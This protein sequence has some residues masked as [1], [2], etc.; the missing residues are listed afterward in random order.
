MCRVRQ[1]LFGDS[2]QHVI[3]YAVLI[4]V[5]VGA[6]I[7]M[8]SYFTGAGQGRLKQA[9]DVIGDEGQYEPGATVV[10]YTIR[11]RRT[12]RIGGERRD[13]WW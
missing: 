4:A 5:L 6:L 9:A 12:T 3:E 8:F 1:L 2:G 10:A 13:G 11:H 7:G